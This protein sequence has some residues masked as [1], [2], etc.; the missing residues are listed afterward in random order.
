MANR[1]MSR[2][3][4]RES[5]RLLA[6]VFGIRPSRGHR[7]WCARCRVYSVL[8]DRCRGRLRCLRC[9]LSSVDVLKSFGG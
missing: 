2:S 9:G 3:Q 1:R 7:E 6:R 8:Y 4:E 5:S